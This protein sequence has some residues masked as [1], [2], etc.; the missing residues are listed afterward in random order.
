MENKEKCP[1]CLGMKELFNPNT[2]IIEKCSF[3]QGEG[4][5][6]ASRADAYDPIDT[7]DFMYE[8]EDE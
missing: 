1:K 3:C 5:V 4:E 2:D 8:E 7:E 6:Y